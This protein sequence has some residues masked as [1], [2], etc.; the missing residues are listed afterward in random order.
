MNTIVIKKS[1]KKL[2]LILIAILFSNTMVMAHKVFSQNLE[3]TFL[4]LSIENKKVTD[5]F[6]EIESQS[7]FTFVYSSKVGL[8]K[9][10]LT[11]KRNTIS[12]K[13]TMQILSS[14]AGLDYMVTG[15]TISVKLEK[16]AEQKKLRIPQRTVSGTIADQE[17]VP[18]PGVN[19]L[20]KGTQIGAS[21]DFDGNYA[22]QVPNDTSVLVFSYV[23]FV[24]QE[25]TVGTRNTINIALQEEATS[26]EQI[27]VIG[28]GQRRR[29]DLVGSVSTVQAENIG[30]Q[31]V[32]TIEQALIGQVAGV[33]FRDNGA[34][35]GGPNIVVRGLASLGNN[36]PLY[37]VDGF[38][39]GN[40]VGSQRD[41]FALS[42]IDP[43]DVQSIS[44]LKDASAK[45][46]YGARASNGVIIITT[47]KGKRGAKPVITFSSNVGIQ[48]IPEYE[49]PDVLN[50]TELAQ[51]TLNALE[52]QEAAGRALGG[53]QQ[54]ARTRITGLL[55]SG[56]LGEGNDWFDLISRDGIVQNYSI[57][58]TGGGEN[59]RYSVTTSLQNRE[60][61][62]IN[63]S[64]KR[65]YVNAN[66]DINIKENLKFGFNVNPTQTFATGGRTDG[67]AANFDVY[68]AVTLSA[69]TDPTAPV[70]E[71]NGRLTGVTQGDLIYRSENINPVT[72]LTERKDERL[73]RRLR[74]GT[75]LEWEFLP[76]LSFKTDGSFQ[77]T[78]RRFETFTPSRFP[79][80]QLNVD[81]DGSGIARSDVRTQGG[82][83]WLFA[84]TLNYKKI[85]GNHK[86]DLLAG[87]TLEKREGVS[88]RSIS[89]NVVDENILLPRSNNTFS[90]EDFEGRASTDGNS[91]ESL[92]GRIDYSFDDRY[93]I[94]ATVRR[95]GS[96][97]FGVDTR[98]GNFWALGGAWRVSSESFFEP[99]QNIFSDFKIDA[100][101]GISGNNTIGNYEAQGSISVDNYTFGGSN[102]PG[103]FPNQVPNVLAEWEES[104]ETNIG[105]D[106][107]FFNN[108]IYI[109]AD[110]YDITSKGFLARVPLPSTSGFGGVSDNTGEINNKGFEIDLSLKLIDKKDFQW[111]A[112]FN[113]SKNEN[114]VI[115][116]VQ[117]R[118]FF[119]PSNSSSAGINITEVRE[120]QSI[121]LFRGYNVTGLFT[122]DDLDNPEVAKYPGAIVGSIKFEDIPTIDTDGDGIPDEADGVLRD[123]DV[124]IIGDA[125]PDF[126]YGFSSRVNYKD[127]D[128]S[129]TLDGAQG[130]DVLFAQG[131][132]LLNQQ[133]GRFNVERVLLDQFRP[134]DD[135][136][137]KTIP[138]SGSTNSR[139]YFRRSNTLNVQDA[140][141]LWVRNI[142][143]GYTLKGDA[144]KRYFKNARIYASV[145]NP[146]LIT[147]YD[148]GSPTTNR[149]GDNALVRNVDYG[150]YPISRTYT[151]G[152]NVTF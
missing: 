58:I 39:I 99:L 34:P 82:L 115:D 137:T 84:N 77:Y 146:F 147:G 81:V 144:F 89:R 100:G 64:I 20:V 63:T 129:V 16:R 61:T 69:W 35:D 71:D 59:S 40:N 130:G 74:M 38:P 62:L 70:F 101:F 131:Q 95:D 12:I 60:G 142:T 47:K 50:A 88:Q 134:G 125:N 135:P 75:F 13:E 27:V 98:Y 23:G 51:F 105:V 26:L 102:A 106:L 123:N 132:A 78:D 68:N 9:E 49:K 44:I 55:E 79:P 54:N 126:V 149:A 18:L 1:R 41:N 87:Y 103:V 65:F 53:L 91:L 151:M 120:G 136:T 111:T 6:K 11:I 21:T 72:L 143:L 32:N 113:F 133:D 5:F 107:G 86:I 31:Q 127:L 56:A 52:D 19:V 2:I 48:S 15:N 110:Y 140:S 94:T 43:N 46:I 22:I 25:V 10:R 83:S 145:Q 36:T 90:P 42:A 150:A 76:G 139:L 17:G 28:Y 104:E 148:Y 112:N 118:G 67:A 14:K 4:K 121:G 80:N 93:Y 29:A 45:A 128:F 119:F 24:N 3:N 108:R 152:V 114:E 33:Q 124:T 7:N 8:L 85:I 30:N 92:I 97:R 141:Y 117:E 138:G 109:S 37:V 116:L 96:S 73:T 122:Q 66:L 57:G